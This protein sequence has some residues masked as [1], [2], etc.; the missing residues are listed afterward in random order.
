[1]I[2]GPIWGTLR[3]SNEFLEL[4]CSENEIILQLHFL[5]CSGGHNNALLCITCIIWQWL[6]ETKW[7]QHPESFINPLIQRNDVLCSITVD[8]FACVSLVFGNKD[9]KSDNTESFPYKSKLHRAFACNV[10]TQQYPQEVFSGCISQ[11]QTTST[12]RETDTW[13][14]WLKKEKR[15][16][17]KRNAVLKLC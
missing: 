15:K 4:L 7:N 11:M 10:T 17:R 5:I 3:F 1:M 16:E 2:V 14:L 6:N 8:M 9:I 12:Q 13:S